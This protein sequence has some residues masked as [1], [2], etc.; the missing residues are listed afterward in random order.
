MISFLTALFSGISR[1]AAQASIRFRILVIIGTGIGEGGFQLSLLILAV[2]FAAGFLWGIGV[3]LVVTH[4]F[5]SSEPDLNY[6][7]TPSIP[8]TKLITR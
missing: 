5:A 7:S 4:L 3:S 2:I 6:N 8:Y 1:P